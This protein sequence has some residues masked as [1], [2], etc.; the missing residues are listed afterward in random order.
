MKIRGFFTKTE[1][2]LLLLT[3]VFLLGMIGVLHAALPAGDTADYV[4]TTQ[5][6]GEEIV[7][8]TAQLVNINT[9][10][11]EELDTLPGIGPV[12]AERI[13]AYREENGPFQTEED[14]LQVSGIGEAKLEELRGQI[15]LE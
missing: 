15:T 6:P 5:L 4:I 1:Y 13:V 7:P 8:E 14:L 3:A 10:T 12:L 2:G 9:A 11:A